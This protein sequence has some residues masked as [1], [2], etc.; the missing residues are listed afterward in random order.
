MPQPAGHD[1]DPALVRGIPPLDRLAGL[2][3]VTDPVIVDGGANKGR[4]TDRF[5]ELFPAGRVLAFEP[6][7]ELARKL[8]KRFSGDARVAVHA[9]ALGPRAGTAEL[10]VFSRRTLSSMLPPT[11]I[12]EK[13]VGQDIRETG[14]VT[15]PMVRLDAFL[16]GGADIIKLDLQGFELAALEGAVGILPRAGL[17]LA[18]TAFY[19]LYDGQP[20]FP[21]LRAFLAGH[22]FAFEGLYDPYYDG[23][24]R[25]ASG[26]ALFLGPGFFPGR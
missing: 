19:P 17:I 3:P 1:V 9:S 7:P 12:H 22:G 2:C 16:P 23:D 10:T 11:G 6:L 18:E 4:I 13:Y 24:G 25:L 21:A 14:R 15:V 26:D 8:A 5:L 20:L